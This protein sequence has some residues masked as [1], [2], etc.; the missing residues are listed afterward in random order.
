MFLHE[1]WRAP[2]YALQPFVIHSGVGA[3]RIAGERG[4]K[5]GVDSREKERLLI[6]RVSLLGLSCS[7]Y[8][9]CWAFRRGEREILHGLFL[10]ADFSLTLL[11]GFQVENL[12]VI[13]LVLR[14][15]RGGG[16]RQRF[17][18]IREHICLLLFFTFGWFFGLSL[19]LWHVSARTAY[20]FCLLAASQ[21]SLCKVG[22]QTARYAEYC[23]PYLTAGCP[24]GIVSFLSRSVRQ[25]AHD[26]E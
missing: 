18:D 17:N 21:H 26:T 14:R 8:F 1:L 19:E 15:G 3:H 10:P 7:S 22:S 25:K 20:P 24:P 9:V 13:T 4:R 5:V 11:K 2:L 16:N 23:H 12:V 6:D